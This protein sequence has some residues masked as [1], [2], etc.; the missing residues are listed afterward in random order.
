MFSS[1]ERLQKRSGKKG[2]DRFQYL[3]ELVEEFSNTESS[4][5]EQ[6][7]ANLANFS[8]DP[9]N[10]QWLRRLKVI[11]IF[12]HHLSEGTVTL[13]RFA[14]AGI[15]N[16]CLDVEN[17]SYILQNGGVH[18]LT[19]CLM[20][21]DESTVISSITSLMF[22]VTPQSKLEITSDKVV[23]LISVKAEESNPR[24]RNLA[25]IFLS[26]YHHPVREEDP[27]KAGIQY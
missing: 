7:L 27:T 11:D 20:S 18:L 14:A 10:Y 19:E 6:V 23:K 8:Y 1:Y 21:E 12:L 24:I 13:H 26:D 2:V 25:K 5:K 3:K 4:A 17:K 15:C 22:L 16:L 9:I